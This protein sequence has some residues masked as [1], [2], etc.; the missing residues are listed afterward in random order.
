MEWETIAERES[1]VEAEA[2][3]I[4]DKGMTVWL[5]VADLGLVVLVVGM[6]MRL[7]KV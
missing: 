1:L 2:R 4:A 5:I 7:A 6:L 3:T